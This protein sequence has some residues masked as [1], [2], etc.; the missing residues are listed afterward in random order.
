MGVDVPEIAPQASVE[1]TQPPT[2]SKRLLIVGVV[3]LLAV[4]VLLVALVPN[5][6]GDEPSKSNPTIDVREYSWIKNSYIVFVYTH[7]SLYP[8]GGKETDGIL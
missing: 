7:L 8:W 4:V 1:G 5:W 3:G 2:T 6:G